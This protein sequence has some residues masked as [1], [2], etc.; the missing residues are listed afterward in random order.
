MG[1]THFPESFGEVVRPLKTQP[2]RADLLHRFLEGGLA[3]LVSLDDQIL[4]RETP[5]SG[6]FQSHLAGFGIKT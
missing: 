6:D 5:Q 4:K 3:S 1:Y 2:R